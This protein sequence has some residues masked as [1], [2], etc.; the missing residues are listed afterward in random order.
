MSWGYASDTGKGFALSVAADGSVRKDLLCA[1]GLEPSGCARGSH[2]ASM[3]PSGH[4][5]DG[6]GF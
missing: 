3:P 2:A 4:V 1:R 6:G 5:D